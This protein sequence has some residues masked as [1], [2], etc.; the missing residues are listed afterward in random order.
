MLAEM[1]FGDTCECTTENIL[2]IDDHFHTIEAE[3]LCLRGVPCA[4]D[5]CGHELG[6]SICT[7]D[8]CTFTSV[9]WR[10]GEKFI[11]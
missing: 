2:C 3:F 9:Y 7:K 4:G 11:I 8:R 6:V 10:F 1:C 5:N